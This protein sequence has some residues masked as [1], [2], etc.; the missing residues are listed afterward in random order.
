MLV[1]SNV[2]FQFQ[3]ADNPLIKNV[4]FAVNVGECVGLIGPNGCGKSTL[5]RIIRGE[6]PPDTGSVEFNPS[7][8]SV[9]YLAQG[10]VA[11]DA[12]TVE[13]V[14]FPRY[15]A[16]RLAEIEVE[17][18]ADQ[19]A[20]GDKSAIQFYDAAL[21][22]LMHLSEQSNYVIGQRAMARI[23]IDDLML[24]TKVGTLSGGQKTRL[25]MA[26]LLAQ[27]SRLLLLD[28]PTNHLDSHA[29][30]WLEEW[31]REFSGGVLLVSH[32]R[33]FIDSVVNR[34]V[35]LDPRTGSAR[36]HVG[37]Y[38]D[39]IATLGAER[40]KQ[41]AEW[42]DQEVEIARLKSDAQQTMARAVR[43]E[44]ATIN[45]HQRR[46]AKKVAHKA[47]AKEKRLERYLASEDRVEKP[48][49]TWDVKMDFVDVGHIRGDALRLE[50][51]SIG[52]PGHEPLLE[53]LTLALRGQERIAVMGP[54]GHG[55]STLLKTIIGDIPP[56][57]GHIR[58]AGSTQI[59]YLA[60]EQ[61]ILDPNA[62]PM[63]T[64]Q[65]EAR[66]N[67]TEARS[68][69][70]F[71]LFA[72]DD[73]LRL[74]SQLSFGERARLMLARLVARGANL[75]IM[76]EP[77]NHLDLTSREKFEQA[78]INFPGSVLTVAHDRYFVQRFA[79]KIWHIEARRL[80]VEIN[81]ISDS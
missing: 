47:K 27:E 30:Q 52:Y 4:S 37:N 35:A 28:E 45:D 53:Q 1:V 58:V 8:L 71:Y 48:E 67:E 80:D 26:S 76:D 42:K 66:M 9:G 49:L 57:T 7:S 32:D 64:V 70:H 31:L 23:G 51:V 12:A 3:G 5:M 22:K 24:N 56:M 44:N 41:W 79:N 15:R 62:T 43:K 46:L 50:D 75:L 36:V 69:L 33:T 11:D 72:G 68:F 73:S 10:V 2:T 63:E 39:Y 61:E 55:K 13:E 40:D 65:R 54:N 78:L 25:M 59:G 29:L 14:L 20:A 60:Q 16:L 19:I 18:L 6:I 74:I 21:E 81:M 17:H 77:L 38:T 34:I